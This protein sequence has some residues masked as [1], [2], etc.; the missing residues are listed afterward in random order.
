[1][2]EMAY[3]ASRP[4]VGVPQYGGC[5]VDIEGMGRFDVLRMW[6]RQHCYG[7][8]VYAGRAKLRKRQLVDE[9]IVEVSAPSGAA[10]DRLAGER[11]LIEHP[12]RMPRVCI[13]SE[14]GQ[15]MGGDVREVKWRSREH[16][17]VA[18]EER[19]FMLHVWLDDDVFIVL[20]KAPA[21]KAVALAA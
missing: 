11:F 6:E 12:G 8:D 4:V 2:K 19:A 10:M 16:L 17:A 20:D 9:L 14:K 13:E 21:R 1:M 7:S 3:E 15:Q 18:E 5:H